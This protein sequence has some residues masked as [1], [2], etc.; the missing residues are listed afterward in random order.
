MTSNS[1]ERNKISSWCGKY[2][3]KKLIWE[4]QHHS[5]IT[6]TWDVLKDNVNKQ[7][8]QWQ[9]QIHVLIQNFRRSNKKTTMHGKSACIFVVLRYGSWCQEMCG[10]ILWVGKQDDST[11]PQCVNSMLWRPPLQKKKNW[12]PWENCQKY[13]LRL[14]WNIYSWHL[15][16]D[17][18][19]Y[20][21]WTNLRDRSQNG[22]KHVTNAWFVWSLTFII[23]V[24]TNNIVVWKTLRNNA[25]WDSFKTPILEEI[26]T[27]QNLHQVE[28]CAF[29]EVIRLFQS[30]GCVRNK[31]LFR[32]VQQNQKSFPWTQD[33]G[34]T[35]YPHLIY[36]I[37]SSQFFT[38]T[39]IRI[40]KNG[41]TST[42]LQCEKNYWKDWWFGQCW[43]Y[44]LKRAF[45]SS[46]SFVVHFWKQRSSNQNYH[47]GKKPYNET[48]FQ[49]PQSC[50]WLVVWQNQCGPP[51]ANQIH[52]HQEATRR[53][54][55]KRK[56]H[57]WWMGSSFV[58][59]QHQPFQLHQ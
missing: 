41:E 15:L 21:Q 45:F 54:I 10:T 31:L 8:Y 20:G 5:L 1:L 25:D 44:F 24:I 37:W 59:A 11:T 32:T 57:T 48:C 2:L 3:T 30:V 17:P 56:L 26:L 18:I 16:E 39:R 46:G 34:W 9:L 40:V 47:K 53:H 29:L 33:K 55:D 58:F 23:H 50:S 4:N 51:D 27:I 22:P 28:H 42:K 12:N 7:R 36:G 52:W 14:S 43:F 13:A 6:Y 19:F 38:E 49:N 35:V